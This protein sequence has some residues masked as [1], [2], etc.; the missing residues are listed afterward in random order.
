M[1][2]TN[3]VLEVLRPVEDPELHKSLV[4]L[5]MIRNVEITG[6]KVSF[7]LVLTTPACPLREFIVEDC[8]KA[9]KQLPG[10]E[11]VEV[12]V[13]AET[14][15]QKS[16]PDR[17]TIAGIKNIVAISSGKGGVGK[18]TIAVNVAVALAQAGAKVGLLDADIYGPNVPTMLGL[19]KAKAIVQQ[20][21]EGEILE[22]AFNHGV[23]MVSMGFLIN[24]DQP[25]IWRGPMLNG[26]IRQFL[27]QVQW[28]ELDYLIV[29]LPPGTGDAQL[30]L[31]Q[32]VPMAG[33]AI[34]TTPQ[35][36]SLLDARRGL[37][38]FQQLGVNVLG[39]VENMS[40]F[41]PPDLP[42]RKYDLFG[43]GGGEKTS[44]ELNVPLLGCVP[45]EISLREG[46]DRGIPIV[47]GSPESAS[48]QALTKI[49]RAIA[50][51]VSVVALA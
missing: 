22:P 37:R 42:E 9:V 27:Y 4:E 43:S 13:T 7:T 2:D 47:T 17:Q 5:N 36:V 26:I 11:E 20:G 21:A 35:N 15:Q 45:L 24:P 34:V 23:K 44:Q 30:T 28:G 1:L 33:A 38:M 50:A 19:E 3:S 39:I 18:S 31:A 46:G 40:Y 8:Q 29:D 12:E 10:V 48:A 41:I 51:K 14:P 25:V 6:G 49:A 32:A 16:L